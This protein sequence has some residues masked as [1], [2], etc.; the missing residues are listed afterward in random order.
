MLAQ[1]LE[2][3]LARAMTD[4][5]TDAIFHEPERRVTV[6]AHAVRYRLRLSI[7]TVRAE[8]YGSVEET[9]GSLIARGQIPPL[10]SEV[11]GKRRLEKVLAPTDDIDVAG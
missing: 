8:Y 9:R 2:V 7:V 1:L 4:F 11:V 10:K 3:Q 6:H 5:T